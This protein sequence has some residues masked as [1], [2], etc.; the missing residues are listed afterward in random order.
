M[1][2]GKCWRPLRAVVGVTALPRAVWG[3]TGKV[4]KNG[5]IKQS[6]CGGCLRKANLDA[7]QTAKLLVEMGLVG[8]DLV[9]RNDWPML[10]KH[11]LVAT[12]V[13]GAGSIKKGLNDKSH[14]RQVPGGFQDE[15]QGRGRVQVAQ[16]DH[17]GRRPGG[18]QR[19]RRAWTTARPSSRKRS[20]SPRTAA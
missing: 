8:R 15:H 10:K 17:H 9:G 14:A 3:Q 1:P 18:D 2:A 20:R 5:R 6:I 11:G 19:R 16:R 13:P 4:V 12:M 7:E